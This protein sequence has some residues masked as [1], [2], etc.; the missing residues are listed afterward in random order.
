VD[1]TLTAPIDETVVPAS[2]PPTEAD[3]TDNL[4]GYYAAPATEEVEYLTP[5]H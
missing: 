1:A 3:F 4:D 5:V 2:A